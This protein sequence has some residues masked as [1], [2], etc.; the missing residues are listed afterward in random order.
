MKIYLCARE[1]DLFKSWMIYCGN[2]DFVIPTK[3]SILDVKAKAL[4]SPANSFGFMT[5]GIDLLYK[6]YFGME[7]ESDLQHI[8]KTE[9][10]GELLVGQATWVPIKHSSYTM[11]FLISA[12]TMRVPEVVSHTINP[13]LAARAALKLAKKLNIDSIV[14]P[15]LGTGTGL[16]T[17]EDCAKQMRAAIDD[18]I[19]NERGFPQNLYD[20]QDHM[21]QHIVGTS[22]YNGQMGR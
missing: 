21:R 4:V 5:G 18:V 16:V 3:Q 20:E 10:G 11:K 14:F 6:N 7:M 8:I 19:I 1:E 9:F 12:P 13:Y 17:A 15:G 2:F 22:W